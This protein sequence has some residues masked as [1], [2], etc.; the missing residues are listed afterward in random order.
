MAPAWGGG[1]DEREQTLNQLLVEM[2]GFESNEGVI[3]IAAT[4]RPDVLDPALLRPG[5]FDRRVMVPSPDVRGR[6]QIL[7][8]HAKDIPLDE[9]VN[10]EKIAKGTPG[11]TGAELANLMNEA[12]L[13]AARREMDAVSMDDV[14]AAKDKVLMGAERR[15]MVIS[16]DEKKTTAYHEAG[17]ALVA[18]MLPGADPVHRVTIIPR[19]RALGVTQQLPTEE[20][21]TRDRQFLLDNIAILMG[22]RAAEQVA[23][24]QVT[25][26]AGNDIERATGLARRMV[27]EWGMSEAMGPLAFGKKEEQIFLGRE[28]AQH[29]DFS[30]ETAR[31]IDAEVRK[32]VTE[33]YERASRILKENIKA[34]HDISLELLDRET[35]SGDDV[36]RLLRACLELNDGAPA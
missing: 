14:E 31:S 29:Q 28:F 5:R 23:L 20:R 8:I 13:L 18:A 7:A 4:N 19:G 21:F 15:S 35:I 27:C 32:I 1:H 33:G 3:L 10:L 26:G 30:E 6:A 24:D 22:G 9:S 36:R 11:F 2:D 12:A 34:L 16:D 25:T 17:H